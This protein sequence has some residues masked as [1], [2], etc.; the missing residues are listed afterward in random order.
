MEYRVPIGPVIN[1]V[2]EKGVL[3]IQNPLIKYLYSL[4]WSIKNIADTISN[5]EIFDN[6][7]YNLAESY[8]N[9]VELINFTEE[10]LKNL[11]GYTPGPESIPNFFNK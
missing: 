4:A 9:I 10:Q 3:H 8:V 5:E 2:S 1:C 7:H 6:I 11:E